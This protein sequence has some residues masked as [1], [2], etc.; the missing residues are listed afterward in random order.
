VWVESD[1]IFLFFPTQLQTM[2]MQ[3]ATAL[4]SALQTKL[5]LDTWQD[6]ATIASD[7]P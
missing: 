4:W 3:E 6:V 2:R 1:D 5:D 7:V